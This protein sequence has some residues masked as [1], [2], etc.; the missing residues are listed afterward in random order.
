MCFP[1]AFLAAPLAGNLLN[2]LFQQNHHGHCHNHGHHGHPGGAALDFA[3]AQDDFRDA[4]REFA[5]GDFAGGFQQ[6]AEGYQHLNDAYSH[7]R[8]CWL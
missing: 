4:R 5:Q 6:M 1:L 2:N 8:G 7:G 3:L